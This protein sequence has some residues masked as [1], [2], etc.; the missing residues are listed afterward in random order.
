ML[1]TAYL[2]ALIVAGDQNPERTKRWPDRATSAVEGDY[3][4]T[5]GI[6]VTA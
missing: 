2:A 6:G 4:A 3:F 1:T 5:A